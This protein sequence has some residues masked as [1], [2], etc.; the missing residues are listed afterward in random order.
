[1]DL[2]GR[3]IISSLLGYCTLG[4]AVAAFI[5]LVITNAVHRRNGTSPMF[6]IVWLAADVINLVGII[7]LGA[8]LTQIL[9]A[10]WYAVV[11]SIMLIEMLMY[12][13]SD[14]PAPYIKP[15][16][17]FLQKKRRRGWWL[18]I[19][20]Q[21]E[22]F[23]TWD[24]IKLGAGCVVGS[25]AWFGLWTIMSVHQNPDYVIEHKTEISDLA[26]GMGMGASIPEMI[27][28]WRRSA[29]NEKPIH[30]V[31]DALF[32]FLVFENIANIAS[33]ASLSTDPAYLWK[34]EL[35]WMLGS[36]IPI[37]G[38]G[39][40]IIFA[41]VWKKRWQ[42]P[43]NLQRLEIESRE[44]DRR[45]Q[46]EAMDAHRAELE[47]EWEAEDLRFQAGL[48]DVE[49]PEKGW[50]KRR[51]AKAANKTRA[52]V[53]ANYWAN[54][55]LMKLIHD[56]QDQRLRGKT[57]QSFTESPVLPPYDFAKFPALN[58]NVEMVCEE[59]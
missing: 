56:R 55:S 2:T 21:F 8:Q 49:V 5:P 36:I 57:G 18:K 9:L 40:I 25:I 39:F 51:K 50:Y 59:V 31:S 3:M 10:A 54:E 47:E 48:P 34:A 20:Q 27:S 24:C 4:F 14:R 13:H 6:L 26:F 32:W 28:G 17:N 44:A 11:D 46:V 41:S 1:M 30:E 33:I 15:T 23:S 29:R 43:N 19:C 42:R 58:I 37:V 45:V 16:T 7:M 38:D 52:A 12:G 53:R 35:P 22:T